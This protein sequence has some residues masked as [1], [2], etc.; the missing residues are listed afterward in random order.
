M[1]S[2]S[3][4]RPEVHVSPSRIGGQADR[5]A[6]R[7]QRAFLLGR[8]Q[9]ALLDTRPAARNRF[10]L[11]RLFLG[12][13]ATRLLYRFAWTFPGVLRG[14]SGLL[15]VWPGQG[16]S[17]TARRL[18]RLSAYLAGARSTGIRRTRLAPRYRGRLRILAYHAV[19]ENGSGAPCPSISPAALRRQLKLLRRLGF[20]FVSLDE[21]LDYLQQGKPLPRRA[22]ALTFDDGYQEAAEALRELL[23]ECRIPASMFVVSSLMGDLNRWDVPAGRPLKLLGAEALRDLAPVLRYGSHG[24]THALLTELGGNAVREE[25]SAS[26]KELEETLQLPVRYVAYPYGESNT[27]VKRAARDSGCL[28]WGSSPE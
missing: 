13:L 3:R 18:G 5:K 2:I 12:G 27:R 20:S 24:R 15:S 10:P 1:S 25:L 26:K 7:N 14:F 28:A 9:V 4:P 21:W 17:G 6:S 11:R 19:Q 8:R 23:L 22:V 16:L